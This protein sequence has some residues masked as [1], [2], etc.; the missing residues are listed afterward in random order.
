[1]YIHLTS[2]FSKFSALQSPYTVNP[3]INPGEDGERGKIRGGGGG[4][5]WWWRRRRRGGGE[6]DDEQEEWEEKQIYMMTGTHFHE[7]SQNWLQCFCLKFITFYPIRCN[8]ACPSQ[9]N[10]ECIN[11]SLLWTNT[12]VHKKLLKNKNGSSVN[13]DATCYELNNLS[14]PQVWQVRLG[15]RSLISLF[16]VISRQAL[17][18]IWP[19]MYVKEDPSEY[20]KY[21]E[22]EKSCTK[23]QNVGAINPCSLRTLMVRSLG[24]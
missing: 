7:L 12:K 10:M 15:Y 16:T 18:S 11:S 1:M 24:T 4:G 2:E 23:I 21:V 3:W 6:D 8:F 19:P 13:N 14:T 17:G 20:I 22:A 5:W 9:N